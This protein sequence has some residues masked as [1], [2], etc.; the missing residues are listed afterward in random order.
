MKRILFAVALSAPTQLEAAST[1][2]PNLAVSHDVT[3]DFRT[4]EQ[5]VT[6]ILQNIK[7]PFDCSLKFYE[8]IR[9]TVEEFLVHDTRS[10]QEILNRKEPRSRGASCVPMNKHVGDF[11]S[12]GD[13]PAVK[14][15]RA[16]LRA[17]HNKPTKSDESKTRIL[18][19][20]AGAIL[21]FMDPTQLRVARLMSD[22]TPDNGEMGENVCTEIESGRVTQKAPNMSIYENPFL[23]LY[24]FLDRADRCSDGASSVE[25]KP[26]SKEKFVQKCTRPDGKLSV[27][28]LYECIRLTDQRDV[29]VR[30]EDELAGDVADVGAAKKDP[31]PHVTV[32]SSSESAKLSTDDPHID[33]TLNDDLFTREF[34]CSSSFAKTIVVAVDAFVR[35]GDAHTDFDEI[36]R[37]VFSMEASEVHAAYKIVS[38]HEGMMFDHV[39]KAPILKGEEACFPMDSHKNDF[40]SM[41]DLDARMI[42]AALRW[43]ARKSG[44]I[45]LVGRVA[46]SIL[47]SLSQDQLNVA[48]GMSLLIDFK[49]TLDIDVCFDDN[50]GSIAPQ[51]VQ[52]VP[53]LRYH[54]FDDYLPSVFKLLQRLVHCAGEE[55]TDL[56]DPK[57]D[58]FKDLLRTLVMRLTKRQPSLVSQSAVPITTAM[59]IA[60]SIVNEEKLFFTNFHKAAQQLSLLGIN[61]VGLATQIQAIRGHI[62]MLQLIDDHISQ[63]EADHTRYTELLI[64]AHEQLSSLTNG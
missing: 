45:K 42:A 32:S 52:A 9:D 6:S 13:E 35:N 14:I 16:I 5:S 2:A 51:F 50:G 40:F 4:P 38:P 30:V 7:N 53:L 23:S 20:I 29:E 26:L 27:K 37:N 18:K 28:E 43:L 58:Q 21:K 11:V 55:P 47:N 61:A 56:L 49:N 60:S 31:L 12:V 3:P 22:I 64:K 19:D 63:L 1:G 48:N 62:M 39:Q 10:F 41:N 17:V 34:T 54:L 36:I 8:F 59:F 25:V 33:A 24:R 46:K 57:S 15:V 44:D